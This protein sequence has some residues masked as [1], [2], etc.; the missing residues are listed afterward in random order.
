VLGRISSEQTALPLASRL[1]WIV[2]L[3]I[4]LGAGPQLLLAG[5]HLWNTD[6]AEFPIIDPA[7]VADR[8]ITYDIDLS[9]FNLWDRRGLTLQQ[10]GEFNDAIR[11][12]FTKWNE[13]LTPL[14]LQFREAEPGELSE[15]SVRALPYDAFDDAF[16]DEPGDTSVAISLGWPFRHVY[17]ILPIW[18]DSTE[19]FGVTQEAPVIADRLLSQPYITIVDTEQFDLYA[20][21]LHEIGHTLGL[22]HL[23]D[24]VRGNYNY[25]FL[26]LTTVQV[27]P[28]SMAV[29]QW[30]GGMQVDRRRPILETELYTVM[31]PLRLAWEHEIPPEDRATVAFTL[32]NLNPA[33]ADEILAEARRLYERTSPLRFANVVYEL[34]K[35]GPNERNN[36]R[37]EAMP[38]VPNQV[39]IG[40]LFGPDKDSGPR[41]SDCFR[42]DLS[43]TPAGTAIILDIDEANGLLDSGATLIQLS[44]Q[45][46]AGKTVA[47]GQAVGT[48]PDAD[49]YSE[50][51]PILH[52]TLQT[53]GVYYIRVEQDEA[54]MPGMY[55]LKVGVGGPAEPAGEQRPAIDSTGAGTPQ[56]MIE[57]PLA[58][59]CPGLGFSLL[60]LGAASLWLTRSGCTKA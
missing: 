56:P 6:P 7:A 37:E 55:V 9:G 47:V 31:V 48:P 43:G 19:P 3:L 30:I 12:A 50:K 5:T 13:V 2:G 40:S 33:G 57:H 20:V 14:G 53:P 10:L 51:D 34:E 39:V 18:F 41:D 27:D 22:G 36:T 45:D 46:A 4:C 17:T 8:T 42:L 1:L 15:L 11:R 54:G 38:I 25:N 35:N 58:G 52:W 26:G 29:S 49:S 21:A 44:L 59:L 60:A 23:G 16:Q 24:A 32:R 28:S